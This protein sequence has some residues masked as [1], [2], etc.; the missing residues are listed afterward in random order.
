MTAPVSRLQSQ[1][2]A[3]ATTKDSRVAHSTCVKADSV[4]III[5]EHVISV[6]SNYDGLFLCVDI[7]CRL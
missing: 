3:S 1:I 4:Q 7:M 5:L 2:H 6:L